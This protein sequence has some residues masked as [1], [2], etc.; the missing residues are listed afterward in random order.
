[1]GSL[2]ESPERSLQHRAVHVQF[3]RLLTMLFLIAACWGF[4]GFS[5]TAI[6]Q[7]IPPEV[8]LKH[9]LQG[10]RFVGPLK[11]GGT[12]NL[13]EDL[14]IFKDGKFSSRLCL[15]YGFAPAPYW[16]RRDAQGLHF[17]AE[18][19][20]PEQGS[21]KFEGIFDGKAMSAT[22]LWRKERW[23]WTIEQKLEFTGHPLGHAK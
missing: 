13:G 2:C 10:M 9:S 17:E 12:T 1:M 21:M 23:Y 14:L 4:T 3:D 8:G 16:V 7:A 15:Q 19:Q 6:G 20:S 5:P 11:A 18:L 22:A